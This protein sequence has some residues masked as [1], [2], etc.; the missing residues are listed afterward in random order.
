MLAVAATGFKIGRNAESAAAAEAILANDPQNEAAIRARYNASLALGDENMIVDALVDLA[1][2]EPETSRQGLWVLALRAYDAE[3]LAQA[4]DLFE[5]VLDVD[6]N[7]ARG[8][9]FLSLVCVSEGINSEAIV[10]LKRFLELAPDDPD[11]A[12]ATELLSF[13]SGS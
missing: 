13:L 4:K 2:V 10:H 8:H 12:T 5:K 7:D 3:D 11:A 9:Y 1:A 6:P